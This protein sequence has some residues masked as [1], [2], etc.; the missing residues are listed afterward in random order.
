MAKL[1]T[2]RNITS[3]DLRIG[4]QTITSLA[5]ATVDADDSKTARDL[6]S[7]AGS[8]TVFDSVYDASITAAIAA[9][10]GA[11][12][13]PSNASPTMDSV[14]AAGASLTYSRGDH[15]HPSD[16]SRA[17]LASP[18]FTG[19][20]QAPTPLTADN[21]TS[22]ATTAFV[23]AQ[24]YATLAS[25]VFTGDPQG[26]TPATGDNDTSLATTAF[27]KAQAYATLANPVFTGD[28]QAPTPATGDNDTSIATTAFVKAQAYAP[29]ASPTFTGDPKGPTPTAG[30][31]DTSIATTAFIQNAL[32]TA[33]PPGVTV[34]YGGAT[35]PTGWLLC[36][37]SQ[38]SRTTYA[39]L[40]A[41]IS[42]TYGVGDGSTTFNVPDT[43]G[44][45]VIGVGVGS[46]LTPRSRNDKSGFEL[47]QLLLAEIPGHNHGGATGLAQTFISVN[48]TTVTGTANTA[49]DTYSGTTSSVSPAMPPAGTAGTANNPGSS[50]FNSTQY[51]NTITAGITS[52]NGS[53]PNH[54]HTFSGTT[55]GHA[56]TL[57][58]NSHAHAI[59]EPNSGAGHQHSIDF[60]GGGGTHNNMQPYIAL[61][62]IIKT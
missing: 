50:G 38:V 13:T 46:G 28:P 52:Y 41:I 19:D 4:T 20:P 43:M 62:Y 44:R 16:T 17:P 11:A 9:V 6:D 31:N 10:A 54:A 25:P 37:G 12:A 8:Y 40:F 47:H 60:E 21:D 48:G 24:G 29:I 55:A 57:T 39:A 1:V 58:M 32:A 33:L 61:N 14:A 2:I 56:H 34:P 27:V 42:T 5:S 53:A 3:L 7:F 26:P 35:A 30:D 15:V 18:V 59:T 36:D 45:T 23:K 49:A 51:T 22:I